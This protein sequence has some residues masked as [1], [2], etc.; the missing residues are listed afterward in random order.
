MKKRLNYQQLQDVHSVQGHR[1]G[2]CRLR[3]FARR[4]NNLQGESVPASMRRRRRQSWKSYMFFV[5]L[6]HFYKETIVILLN[7]IK[8]TLIHNKDLTP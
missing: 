7:I 4:R 3:S 2:I 8:Q 5:C 6:H 1:I